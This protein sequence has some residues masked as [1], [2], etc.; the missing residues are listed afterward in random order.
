MAKRKTMGQFA[1][2]LS[3]PFPPNKYSSRDISVVEKI[4]KNELLNSGLV[5]SGNYSNTKEEIRIRISKKNRQHNG[6]KKKHKRTNNDLQNIHIKLK[7]EQHEPHQ[8]L[9]YYKI[10]RDSV[11]LGDKVL[12]SDDMGSRLIPTSGIK[13]S[14]YLPNNGT[15]C[16]ISF[17]AFSPQ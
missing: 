16:Y 15:V 8:K 13:V 17:S 5:L 12:T 11:W 10:T 14:R 7:I 6:Q 3:Q 1:I 2:S 4:Y 9:N